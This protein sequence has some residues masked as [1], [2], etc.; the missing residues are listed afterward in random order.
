MYFLYVKLKT[1]HRQLAY[2]RILPFEYHVTY[3]FCGKPHIS[4]AKIKCLFVILAKNTTILM[5]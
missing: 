1:I 5:F 3:V 4:S 2:Q